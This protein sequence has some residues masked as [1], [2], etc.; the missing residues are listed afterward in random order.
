M[1]KALGAGKQENGNK[2]NEKYGFVTL[3]DT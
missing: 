2:R 1:A 3:Q